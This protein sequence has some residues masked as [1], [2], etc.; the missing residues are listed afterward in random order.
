MQRYRGTQVHRYTGTQIYKCM[1][2]D[3]LPLLEQLVDLLCHR[4]TRQ[5]IL[6]SS[7]CPRYSRYSCYFPIFCLCL[8]LGIEDQLGMGAFAAVE[9][10][11]LHQCELAC[12]PVCLF[13]KYVDREIEMGCYRRK[14]REGSE[15][16]AASALSRSAAECTL[17]RSALIDT[18]LLDR[19]VKCSASAEPL[20]T[21]NTQ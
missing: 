4:N 19:L 1:L 12:H 7:H 21:L 17:L 20:H 3:S 16:S 8:C 6:P 15:G 9:G 18:T 13:S 2:I 5:L 14:E 10:G 11:H